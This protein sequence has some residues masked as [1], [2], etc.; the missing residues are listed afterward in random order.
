MLPENLLERINELARKKKSE[1]LTD[2]EL[3]EQ[4]ELRDQ[5]IKLFR[6]QVEEQSATIKVVDEEGT[7]VTPD[8]LKELKALKAKNNKK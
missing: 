5:Y 2:L 4:K 8:K 1:G 6:N 7:D 3:K